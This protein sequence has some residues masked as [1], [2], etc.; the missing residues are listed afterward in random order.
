[1]SIALRQVR[2]NAE[3]HLPALSD[4]AA[5]VSSNIADG[6]IA[7]LD[8]RLLANQSEYNELATSL[9]ARQSSTA[10]AIIPLSGSVYPVSSV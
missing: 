3:C 4:E 2:R 1:M 9:Q 8:G 7:G 5:G 6:D 10:S